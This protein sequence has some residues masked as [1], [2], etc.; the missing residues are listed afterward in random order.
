MIWPL[1][2]MIILVITW[3]TVTMSSQEAPPISKPSCANICGH[4]SIPYPFG[5]GASCAHDPWYEIVCNRS[6]SP[7]KPFL[8]RLKLEVA[9]IMDMYTPTIEVRTPPQYICTGTQTQQ[10]QLIRSVDL[11]GSP[12]RF[13][14][15][16]NAFVA[17]GCAGSVVLMNR[18]SKILALCA[19][20]ACLN[21]KGKEEGYRNDGCTA[22]IAIADNDLD[23]YQIGFDNTVDNLNT[24]TIAA[25][26]SNIIDAFALDPSNL[27]T[28]LEWNITDLSIQSPSYQN[29]SCQ[30]NELLNM[31]TCECKE[32]YEG[33][34][35]LPNGCQVDPEWETWKGEKRRWVW[36]APAI[37]VIAGVSV[38]VRVLILFL[39]GCF[40][41]YRMVKKAINLKKR[42]KFFKQNGGLLLQQHMSSNEGVLQKTKIFTIDELERVS[43]NFN[44]SRI[45]G[46]GGQGTVYKGMLMD[47]TIVAIKKSKHV[48]KDQSEQFINELFILSQISHRNIVQ[49]LGC[50]LETKVPMLVYEFIP[51]GTLS[52]HIHNPS[53]DFYITWKIRLQIA[54]ETAGALAYLHSSSSVPIY[55]RDIKCSNILLDDKYRA[56]VSDFGISRTITIDQTHLTTFV[57]GTFGYFD[58]EYFQ[59]NQFTEKSDVYSF[60]VVLVELLTSKKP[61]FEIQPKEWRS[62]ATEFLFQMENSCLFD[63]LDNQV[64][65]EGKEE[66]LQAVANLAR[67]CLNLNGKL[68][69]TMKEVASVLEGVRS[70]HHEP[71]LVEQNFSNSESMG[72]EIGEVI[73]YPLSIS[74]FYSEGQIFSTRECPPVSFNTL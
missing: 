43:D 41:L 62:L 30:L 35:Y 25:L 36:V 32:S 59:S 5:I 33:N 12:Y 44:Q 19:S 10:Q 42:A 1:L 73:N 7:A 61:I 29:S 53:D 64:L 20:S 70:A 50:C 31:V 63:I 18:R 74:R 8:S 68:R 27:K 45:L 40:W 23:F 6:F 49:L 22:S 17:I 71:I 3:P 38:G 24:C 34:P 21:P 37:R 47:G 72:I 57:K 66:E 60:G 46:Q 54:I 16:S 55:H 48:E 26:A 9:C 69:P 58:P 28:T 2:L 4:V 52:Q 67:K 15:D 65:L 13:S 11:R 14:V 51:N 56:K 39:L